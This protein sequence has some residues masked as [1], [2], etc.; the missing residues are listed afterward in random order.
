[1]ARKG[2]YRFRPPDGYVYED[3]EAI[4]LVFD[5]NEEV[6]RAVAL[7]FERY[8]I[9]GTTRGVLEHFATHGLRFPARFGRDVVWRRLTPSRAHAA[10]SNPIYTGTYVYG[11]SRQETILDGGMRRCRT[12]WRPMKDWPV[13]IRG[14]H[15]AYIGWE[16]FMANQARMGERAPR[17]SGQDGPGA[18]REG[19]AL[20]QGLLLCGRCA[21]RL[22]I[23]YAGTDGRFS[24]YR[25]SRLQGEAIDSRC[26][27]VSSRY[28]DE[29]V[30][31]LVMQTLTRERLLDATQIVDIVEQQDAAIE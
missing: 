28:V 31:D 20:L 29:P 23:R 13:V 16:E 25:C 8:R 30:V 24:S 18:E 26:L 27:A 3:D 11:R 22:T 1:L 10:L 12:R 5:P 14:A 15:P 2:E 17:R 19:R 6:H 7:L 21:A 4:A 9:S